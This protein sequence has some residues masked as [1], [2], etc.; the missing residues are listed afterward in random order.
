VK[1]VEQTKYPPPFGNCFAACVASVLECELEDVP[2]P[3]LESHDA[4]GFYE[5]IERV[6]VWLAQRNL[7]LYF[8]DLTAGE[9]LFGYGICFGS[10]PGADSGHCVVI[11]NGDI[12]WDP[13]T[14]GGN[15]EGY[16]WLHVAFFGVIDPAK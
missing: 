2:Q 7:R 11:H 8:I 4:D 3:G 16:E 1:N 6:Q 5:Y 13:D 9:S 12:V 15:T 10:P 14:R